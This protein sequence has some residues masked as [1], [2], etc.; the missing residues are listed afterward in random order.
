M[1]FTLSSKPEPYLV[2]AILRENY[3]KDM[4]VQDIRARMPGVLMNGV[5]KIRT[6]T[7]SMS[8]NRFRMSAGLISW[9]AKIGSEAMKDYLD[10]LLP[11]ECLAAN[12]TR[13]FRNLY[14]HEVEE[15]KLINAGRFPNKARPGNK[16][17]SEENKRKVFEK[18]AQKF[19]QK[20]RAFDKSTEFTSTY[21]KVQQ[22]RAQ[23]EGRSYSGSIENDSQ[24]SDEE[25][26]YDE[27]EYE[28]EEEDD[29]ELVAID[30]DPGAA[31][32]ENEE[33]DEEMV[34]LDMNADADY[35]APVTPIPEEQVIDFRELRPTSYLQID[36]ISLMLEPSRLQF[37]YMTGASPPDRVSSESYLTQYNSL[38]SALNEYT[39]SEGEEEYDGTLIGL[40]EFTDK[41][42]TWNRPWCL[43]AFGTE[44]HQDH[45]SLKL[46][47]IKQEMAAR[48]ISPEI[49]VAEERGPEPMVAGEMAVEDI[50]SMDFSLPPTDYEGMNLETWETK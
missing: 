32:S 9:S 10:I 31:E 46:L 41:K 2:E 16:N 44:P 39:A 28:N 19:R 45:V 5:D 47:E 38:L 48:E 50:K 17:F 34:D 7:I 24:A 20:R 14:P 3:D 40:T 15:M 26:Y 37:F 4:Q 42:W 21:Y 36:L 23:R 18:A 49:K 29:E 35:Q 12:C 33:D 43:K 22:I 25:S 6:G 30:M 8:I 11:P 1:P 27:E 13:S